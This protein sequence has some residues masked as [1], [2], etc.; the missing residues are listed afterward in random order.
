MKKVL[1][2]L[3]AIQPIVL[4][5]CVGTVVKKLDLD[6]DTPIV[7]KLAVKNKEVYFVGMAHLA[8]Q[9][10]YDNTKKIIENLQTE[11]FVFYVESVKGLDPQNQINDTISLKKLRKLTNVD[12]GMKYS[13]SQ[14]VLLQKIIKQY[15]LVDQ[16]KYEI[17]GVKNYKRVDYNVS[18]LVGFYEK[19]YS[20]I[21]LDSCDL[22]TGL[23]DKYNCKAA[24]FSQ[25][26]KF[27]NEIILE[28]RNNLIVDSILNSSDEKI[29]IIYGRKHLEGIRNGLI[30]MKIKN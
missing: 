26:Q 7:E 18:Q 23:G 4:C 15:N 3:I 24:K 12:L 20:I 16:P 14:N 19:K 2:Y 11:G 30:N 13:M 21:P 8:K 29:V 22:K 9:G 25:R 6:S 1:L 17:L 27:S 5:S 28:V 10:F